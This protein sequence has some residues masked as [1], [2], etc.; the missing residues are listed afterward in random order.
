MILFDVKI[1]EMARGEVFTALRAAI[2]MGLSVVDLVVFVRC[3]RESLAVWR[4]GTLHNL[5]GRLWIS[6]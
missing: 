6:V 3:E 4:E 5:G 2:D 1:Q